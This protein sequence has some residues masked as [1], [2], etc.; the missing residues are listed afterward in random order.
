[1]V[2]ELNDEY[3]DVSL[4][5]STLEVSRSGYYAWKVRPE[6]ER[7]VEPRWAPQMRP[8]VG[9]PKPASGRSQ[10]ETCL[11]GALLFG[12]CAG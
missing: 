2:E 1:M 7:S 4:L 3:L 11:L 5:C 12:K 10:D 8:V 6:S 9:T